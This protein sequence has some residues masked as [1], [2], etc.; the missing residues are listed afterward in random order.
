MP[1]QFV[2]DKPTLIKKLADDESGEVMVGDDY[3]DSSRRQDRSRAGED[4]KRQRDIVLCV[5]VG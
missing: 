2:V 5:P 1:N 3:F 4:G